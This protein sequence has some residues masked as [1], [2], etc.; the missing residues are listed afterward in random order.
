MFQKNISLLCDKKGVELPKGT[1]TGTC[2]SV[3]RTDP[4][5]PVTNLI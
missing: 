1:V 4:F 2:N 5:F 3:N